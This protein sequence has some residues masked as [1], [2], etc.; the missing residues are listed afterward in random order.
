MNLRSKVFGVVAALGM[1]VSVVG[2]ATAADNS[3]SGSDTADVSVNLGEAGV[4][5]VEITSANITG[6]GTSA[7]TEEQTT[8]GSINMRYIDTKSY[9]VGFHTT[10]AATDFASQTLV[11]PYSSDPYSIPAE[12]LTVV[13]NYNPAQ[14]RWTNA[15]PYRIGDIGAT[16]SGSDN[17]YPCNTGGLDVPGAGLVGY[18]E[19]GP[20]DSTS[21]DVARYIACGHEGPG[22]AGQID[23]Y[24]F[25]NGTLHKLDVELLVPAGQP[26][27]T[28]TST[29]TLTVTPVGI[30]G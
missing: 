19:W 20:G 10:M 18:E 9:R 22:T 12:N 3:A 21:L 14:G 30:D 7:T 24:P 8:T 16:Q 26:A 2:P 23:P 27:D 5:S 28:Y 6:L 1:A 29:L 15:S 25:L 17:G 4:F 11:Q 13:K